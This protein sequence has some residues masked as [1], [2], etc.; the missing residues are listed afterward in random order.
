MTK[1]RNH[2]DN[3]K[4]ARDAPVSV[5]KAAYKAPCQNYHPDKFPGGSKEAERIMKIVNA[6]Y[7]VLI[8]PV[9]RAIHDVWIREQEAK[10][11]H[12]SEKSQY[13][14]T[15]EETGQQH[16]QRQY[17]PDSPQTEQPRPFSSSLEFAQIVVRLWCMVCTTSKRETG[18]LPPFKTNVI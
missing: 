14:K 10:V 5:I 12:E 1:I 6:S 7:V 3:L 8:D 16:Y 17:K 11:K 13:G 2:Y 4:V 15:G 9:K 18:G